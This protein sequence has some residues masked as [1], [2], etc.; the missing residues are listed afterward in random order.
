MTFLQR[1]SGHVHHHSNVLL[2]RLDLSWLR[3]KMPYIGIYS[4][5]CNNINSLN[6]KCKW[7]GSKIV[8]LWTCVDRLCVNVLFTHTHIGTNHQQKKTDVCNRFILIYFFHI[9]SM[10]L[11]YLLYSRVGRERERSKKKQTDNWYCYHTPKQIAQAAAFYMCV[12]GHTVCKCWMD[13]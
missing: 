7:Y 9:T 11:N 12:C 6:G 5:L 10:S 1:S 13:I 8:S 2:T 4:L 3:L